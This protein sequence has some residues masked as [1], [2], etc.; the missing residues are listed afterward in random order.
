MPSPTGQWAQKKQS[1]TAHLCHLL[2]VQLEHLSGAG[3]RNLLI[4]QVARMGAVTT[5]P[6]QHKDHLKDRQM[7][8]GGRNLTMGAM[9]VSC[10]WGP[11]ADTGPSAHTHVTEKGQEWTPLR[12]APGGYCEENPEEL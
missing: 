8:R 7:Y 11:G 10:G 4:G 3:G 6:R 1:V 2:L 12:V 5:V 9:T